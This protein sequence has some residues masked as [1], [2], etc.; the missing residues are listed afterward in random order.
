MLL[1][2][3]N[4]VIKNYIILDYYD[5][6]FDKPYYFGN[7]DHLNFKGA[8]DLSKKVNHTLSISFINKVDN[9]SKIYNLKVID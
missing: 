9:K 1:F 6:Y 4:K 5:A 7:S 8:N 3:E 2:S